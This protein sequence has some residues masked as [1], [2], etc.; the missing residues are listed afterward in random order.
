MLKSDSPKQPAHTIPPSL[1]NGT[2]ISDSE[3]ASYHQLLF[4]FQ[5]D[6]Q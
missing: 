4:L 5:Q 1:P 2:D 6:I 3:S